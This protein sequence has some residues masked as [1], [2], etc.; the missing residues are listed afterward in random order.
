M[1]WAL[2]GFVWALISAVILVVV[3][4]YWTGFSITDY[5]AAPIPDP[6]PDPAPAPI[7]NNIP[8]LANLG[9]C[10][11]QNPAM[12]C[13][14]CFDRLKDAY[15][16]L[17]QQN[18]RLNQQNDRSTTDVEDL[19]R[20][21]A[22]TEKELNNCRNSWRP[23][24]ATP[25]SPPAS[26]PSGPPS[27]HSNADLI[28]AKHRIITLEQEIDNLVQDR[29]NMTLQYNANIDKLQLQVNYA[30]GAGEDKNVAQK[31]LEDMRVRIRKLERDNN[32]LAMAGMVTRQALAKER[33]THSE[34][35]QDE[36]KCS[37]K[38]SQLEYKCKQLLDSH[39][40][41]DRMVVDAA[42]K[43]GTPK[44]EAQHVTLMSYLSTVT[45]ELAR[46]RAMGVQGATNTV[47]FQVKNLQE[48]NDRITQLKNRLER[49]V[50]RLGGDVIGVRN[51]WDTTRPKDW[52]V[53]LDTTYE[54]NAYRIFPIYERLGE[55]VG[56]LTN[57]F[58]AAGIQPP[59]WESEEPR[60]DQT[61]KNYPGF[62]LEPNQIANSNF[63]TNPTVKN[64]D[65]LAHK[66]TV[67]EV[68]R[69]YNRGLALSIEIRR[70][71]EKRERTE[72]GTLSAV[73]PVMKNADRVFKDVLH[74]ILDDIRP[75]NQS[76][77]D[78]S[79]D[80]RRERK[81]EIY[82]AMQQSI[83][84]L[85][86]SILMNDR[87]P[88]A[89]MAPFEQRSR[90]W[91]SPDNLALNLINEEMRTLEARI[92]QLLAF[93]NH[94]KLPGTINGGPLTHLQNDPGYVQRW[95]ELVASTTFAQLCLSHWRLHLDQKPIQVPDQ[96][97]N[98]KTELHPQVTLL[99][100]RLDRFMRA[101]LN[102][103]ESPEEKRKRELA[104]G[105]WPEKLEPLLVID[106]VRGPKIEF[107]I[108]DPNANNNQNSNNNNFNNNSNN[109][110]SNNSN[111]NNA[112]MKGSAYDQLR[113]T[114]D[115]KR[116][117]IEQ[118]KN[119]ITQWGIRD[120]IALPN[121]SA[122]LRKNADAEFIK[123]ANEAFDQQ[124]N[125]LT[126]HIGGKVRGDGSKYQVPKIVAKGGKIFPG[127]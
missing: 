102:R 107:K 115:T 84:A 124:I 89:W 91:S 55:T 67:T 85:T 125:M 9:G 100:L 33:E 28:H 53:S 123:R 19:T 109:N 46:L 110:S 64:S 88:P 111:N 106:P 3:A 16:Q 1:I 6:I 86:N 65:I 15:I 41:N 29:A 74:D 7:P 60:N 54:E 103:G 98:L 99:P 63:Y 77:T 25:L 39:A 57:V 127:N 66:L 104:E 113:K 24:V 96:H 37:R 112:A 122:Q 14:W 32:A 56:T 20:R 70:L 50:D 34:K 75:L 17:H 62:Q 81:F 126:N 97:G 31:Q 117:R 11:H 18:H 48:E 87:V 59:V 5:F 93:M 90:P 68:Q 76:P 44:E 2:A 58:T 95:Y 101:A 83:H 45:R 114:W 47:D 94:Y 36:A 69:L 51:G 13:E 40:Y 71:A 43:F 22:N 61:H 30:R 52:K 12:G 119:H 4:M 38:I 23:A 78:Q 116:Q 8:R 42:F 80:S 121:V 118:L 10:E 27:G 73:V 21:L 35:C 26:P 49:E 79:P 108:P 105:A 120:N 72:P 82:T 92:N